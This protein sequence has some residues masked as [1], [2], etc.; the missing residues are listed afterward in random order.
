LDEY[1]LNNHL[2]DYITKSDFFP[3]LHSCREK[4]F[5]AANIKAAFEATG[6]HPFNHRRVL[7]KHGIKSPREVEAEKVEASRESSS[8]LLL[9]TLPSTPTRAVQVSSTF[10][11]IQTPG[12]AR[13][14]RT[15]RQ[16]LEKPENIQNPDIVK[17]GFEALTHFGQKSSAQHEIEKHEHKILRTQ[18]T[19]VSIYF[20]H[21]YIFY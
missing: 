19:R 14:L 16:L 18:K 6:I 5:T 17:R 4:V 11:E 8:T 3:I 20:F 12:N 13:Q 10:A 7:L 2:G 1:I 21:L 15:L 9:T